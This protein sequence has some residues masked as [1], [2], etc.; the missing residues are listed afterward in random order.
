[1]MAKK[2]GIE[3]NPYDR[4][5]VSAV[6]QRVKQGTDDCLETA[7]AEAIADEQRANKT[8]LEMA[9]RTGD[10]MFLR[11][12]AQEACHAK[13]LSSLYYLLYGC[14]PCPKQE[15]RV[16][17]C[18]VC[19]AVRDAFAGELSAAKKYEELAQQHPEHATLFCSI[20][21]TERCHANALRSF[22][23]QLLCK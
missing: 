1:M 17:I 10:A 11:I 19:Q 7:L 4:A 18:N 3:M 9:R 5:A 2:G 16:C 20:A 12:A 23:E 14:P 8:Y 13:K 15:C 22:T 21:K 6:W